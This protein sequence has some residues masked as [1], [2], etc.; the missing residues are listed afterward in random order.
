MSKIGRVPIIVKEGVS[1]NIQNQQ[2]QIS[3]PKGSLSFAVPQGVEVKEEDGKITVSKKAIENQEINASFGL[4]RALI[5]NMVK[6]VTEGF[7]K[8]LEL[9][10]VGYRAVLSGSDLLLSVGFSH[11]VK[12]IAPQGV[13]FSVSENV[14]SV[15]GIDKGQVGDTAAKIRAIRPPEPYKGKGI[16]YV[17]EKVRRKAGKAAKAVGTK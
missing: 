2:I 6:G 15:S 1:I 11:P 12:V 7:E 4:T 3:G 17:G 14:I 5:A 10:G 13:K 9:S 16:R 8:R